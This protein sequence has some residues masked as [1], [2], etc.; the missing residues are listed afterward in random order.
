L[1]VG[2]T[3]HVEYTGRAFSQDAQEAMGGDIVRALIELI[4]NCDDAYATFPASETGK[5]QVAIDRRTGQDW[6]VV[7]RDRATGMTADELVTKITKLGGRTSGFETGGDLRGNLGRGAKDVA[8]FGDVT[9]E[10]IRNDRYSRLVLRQD[11]SVVLEA[12]ERAKTESRGAIGVPRGHGTSVTVTV[13]AGVRCPR[14]ETLKARLSTHYQLRDVLA[15]SKRKVE[16][17]TANSG[18][19]DALVYAHPAAELVFDEDIKVEGYPEAHAHLR[20]MRLPIRC[21]EGPSTPTRPS[22]ILVKGRR[23][24]YENTLFGFENR[25]AAG[26]FCGR[27]D[28]TFIDELAQRF[29]TEAESGRP[30]DVRNPARII[31]RRRDGLMLSHPFVKALRAAAEG[32]LGRLVAAEEEREKK[33]DSQ[34]EDRRARAALDRCAQELSQMLSD[35]LREMEAEDLRGPS[36]GSTPALSLV[37]EN[38]YAYLGE[39]RTLTVLVRE[40]AIPQGATV[41]VSCDPEGVLE[42]MTPVVDLVR[43]GHRP[44]LLK[45]QV[46]LRPLD[47]ASTIVSAVVSAHRADAIVEVRATREVEEVEVV[48]PEALEFERPAYRVGLSREKTLL[49]RAPARLVA[50]LGSQVSVSSNQPGVVVR[51]TAAALV[52]NE[53]FEFY[54]A[55]VRI[56]GRRLSTTALLTARLGETSASTN[57]TVTQKEEGPRYRIRLV[58]EDM[59]PYRA[60]SET[61]KDPKTGEDIR[62]LKV[63]A[64]H[65]ALRPLLAADGIHSR[66]ARL[67]IAEAVADVSAR[68][69]VGVLYAQLRGLED[70][71]SDRVYTEHYRRVY[72]LLPRIQQVLLAD[73]ATGTSA[74]GLEADV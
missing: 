55:K 15:D 52:L 5:I 51:T 69:L 31:S 21:D 11:G 58:D 73:L 56:E 19:T 47:E 2:E 8:A 71:P 24:I 37:P 59:S 9:F 60:V 63:W 33:A 45:G 36:G 3:G 25:P 27:L 4:T 22:G 50:N 74:L 28:C 1:R 35:E 65:P 6:T 32:P 54:Q 20:L 34:V 38:A 16:L 53:E 48:P 26:W 49:V 23:A 68:L 43:H 42:V 12:N 67:V 57:V 29:D 44:D 41:Q 30:L 13:R 46:R 62:V 66:P 64:R 39:D 70:F 7:V 10:S 61:E 72:R 14:R 17:Y 18:I 40:D